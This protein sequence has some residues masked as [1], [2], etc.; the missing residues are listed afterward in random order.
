MAKEIKNYRKFYKDYFGI[1][2]S[3]AYV[4]HHIDLNREN[5]NIENLLLMPRWLHI[6]YHQKLNR[7]A[8]KGLI[9]GH[10][11]LLVVDVKI[12]GNNVNMYDY[13]LLSDLYETMREC[14]KWYDYKKY[15]EG[16]LPNIH[17]IKLDKVFEMEW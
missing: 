10:P 13:E 16:V 12:K 3:S 1:E 14:S 6:E 15:L 7:F 4:I 2:F 9:T 8:G 11:D 5:N 17:G